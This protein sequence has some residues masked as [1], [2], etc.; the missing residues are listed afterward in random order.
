MRMSI[1]LGVLVA[2]ALAGGA[3]Q[4]QGVCRPGAQVEVMWRGT[5]YPG[6]VKRIADAAGACPIGYDGFGANWDESVGP[7]RLRA[8]AAAPP[9]G[10]R[11]AGPAAPAKLG[12][13]HCVYFV[14]GAGLMTSPGFTLQPGGRY[15]HD[16]GGGGTYAVKG[17]TLEFGGGPLDRQAGKVEPAVVRLWNERRSRTVI[18]C[19]NR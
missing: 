8:R 14:G 9:S 19:D 5:W 11:L 6:T 16:N 10:A 3:A 2:A 7:E 18:D 17:D 12:H 4:A 13:Y 15:R 1:G